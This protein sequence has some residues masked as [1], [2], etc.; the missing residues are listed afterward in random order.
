MQPLFKLITRIQNIRF[1]KEIVTFLSL[2][3]EKTIITSDF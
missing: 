3:Q 1:E 2:M